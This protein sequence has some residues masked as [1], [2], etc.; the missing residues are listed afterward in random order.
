MWLCS[1]SS[2]Q[3]VANVHSS[4]A[5]LR[6]Q[7]IASNTYIG[8]EPSN[9]NNSHVHVMKLKKVFIKQTRERK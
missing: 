2:R 9:I 4:K 1:E 7:Q 6:G 5:A 3:T 8:N